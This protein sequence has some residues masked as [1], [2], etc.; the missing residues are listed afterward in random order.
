V[1]LRHPGSK[2]TNPVDKVYAFSGLTG[3]YAESQARI[4]VD[5]GQ[6]VRT[7]YMDVARKIAAYD[8]SLDIL[9]LPALQHGSGIEALPSWVP[10]WSLPTEENSRQ[11]RYT[12]SG[13]ANS[14]AN[15]EEAGYRVSRPFCA[16]K[17]TL[18]TG[19]L[20]FPRQETLLA[21]RGHIVD[22]VA[23]V[24]DIFEGIYIATNFRSIVRSIS[25][26]LRMRRTLLT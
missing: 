26:I 4:E 10:D 13:E 21:T 20:V 23:A 14:L 6:D 5:Y 7:V 19:T 22:T 25:S 12:L 2:A 3:R 17:S 24:G 1:L 15:G 8:K 16:A 18:Y 9:S 11:L